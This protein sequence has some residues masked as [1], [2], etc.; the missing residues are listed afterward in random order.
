MPVKIRSDFSLKKE[1][2]NEET[3]TKQKTWT[4][5]NQSK[6]L[7]GNQPPYSGNKKK[8]KTF[9]THYDH[10]ALPATPKGHLANAPHSLSLRKKNS[11][12]QN[13]SLVPIDHLFVFQ[14]NSK[15]RGK[16]R[17]SWT[18]CAPQKANQTPLKKLSLRLSVRVFAD[19]SP[20]IYISPRFFLSVKIIGNFKNFVLLYR[21]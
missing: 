13:L 15:E 14:W 6:F 17:K 16:K 8:L 3:C 21:L 4:L 7:Y 2:K 5:K 1:K 10:N 12:T 9:I 20:S 19:S 11:N 18:A